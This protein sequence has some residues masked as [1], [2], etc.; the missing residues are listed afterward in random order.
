MLRGGSGFARKCRYPRCGGIGRRRATGEAI[1]QP[2]D[3]DGEL[4]VSDTEHACAD[5]VTFAYR[6]YLLS[7][8]AARIAAGSYQAH[9]VIARRS[10][11]HIVAS[12]FVPAPRYFATESEAIEHARTWALDWINLNHV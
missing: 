11:L 9:A 3:P 7:C 12:R 1:R 2:I 8:N 10:D 6:D 4:I 5:L